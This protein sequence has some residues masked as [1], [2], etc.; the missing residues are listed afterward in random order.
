MK[1]H[2]VMPRNQPTGPGRAPPK[3]RFHAFALAL[4][5]ALP[6]PAVSLAETAFLQATSS[7]I[8][9]LR[10]IVRV[11]GE[12]RA[13][14]WAL[15]PVGPENPDRFPPGPTD[16][17]LRAVLT[18]GSADEVAALMGDGP[19]EAADYPAPAWFP[20]AAGPG[21]TIQVIRHHRV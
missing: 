9:D 1:E 17:L 6:V 8:D 21:R 5:M 4:C 15:E 2:Q 11:A 19:T 18:Y 16:H 3:R 7:S 10:R 14:L 12:P 13:A 20:K